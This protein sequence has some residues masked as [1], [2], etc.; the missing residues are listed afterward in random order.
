[1]VN[2]VQLGERKALLPSLV[3][4][5]SLLGELASRYR[6]AAYPL[7]RGY[8]AMSF[9]ELLLSVLLAGERYVSLG[10]RR[11]L[12][13]QQRQIDHEQDRLG[14][15]SRS[16]RH[17]AANSTS[18]AKSGLRT[19]SWTAGSGQ[20]NPHARKKD[21]RADPSRLSFLRPP[22]H[23]LPCAKTKPG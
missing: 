11:S 21:G 23:S 3:V 9:E 5:N 16:K 7:N 13:T 12:F 6:N 2:L 17:S 22:L 19:K 20:G 14:E 8:A 4:K 10:E 15:T 1:M 18:K